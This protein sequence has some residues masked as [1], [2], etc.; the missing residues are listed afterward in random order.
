VDV[1]GPIGVSPPQSTLPGALTNATLNRYGPD[2]KAAAVLAATNRLLAD[3]TAAV[4]AV[5]R[6][7]A[8]VDCDA[9]VQL[10]IWAGL[11]VE[12]YRAQPAL[13]VAAIQARQVQRSL[14]AR[15]GT[16]V[17]RGRVTGVD[18]PSE[19]HP[20]DGA[21]S[22]DSAPDAAVTRWQPTSFDLVDST[23]PLL[24]LADDPDTGRPGLVPLD[25]LD[26][27]ASAWCQRLLGIG[28]PGRGV[29]W[30]AE[31]PNGSRRTYAMVRVG[32]VVAPFV[33]AT[34]GNIP[35]DDRKL[36]LPPLPDITTLKA[37][38]LLHR[39]AYLLM[40]HVVSNYV[41]YHGL[42]S[43]SQLRTQTREL[44][45]TAVQL[46][47]EV[48]DADDPVTLQLQAYA[49]YLDVWALPRSRH[50]ASSAT[51]GPTATEREAA[52]Q[53]LIAAQQ[54]V[55]KAWR[56]GQLDPGAAAYLL[57]IGIVA[58]RDA[59]DP[60]FLGASVVKGPSAAMIRSWWAAILE[61][62]GL[63][64]EAD[65]AAL[66][67][68]L[69]EAQVFHLH[70][71]VDW[72]AS[73]GRRVDLRRVVIGGDDVTLAC[74]AALAVPFVRA[75]ADAFARHTA[76]QPALAAIAEAATGH[77]ALTASAGIA[78]VKPHHPFSTAYNLAEALTVS[79][80]RFKDAT[81]RT[82]AAFDIH[83]A[84]TSTLRDLDQLREYIHR[85]HAPSIAR[86]A[87]PYLL[88]R[89]EELPDNL[90][91]RSVEVLDEISGW[92]SPGGWLSAAQAHALREAADRSWDEYRIQV[93]L[94]IS[95][96]L[97]RS[98]PGACWVFRRIAP[99]VPGLPLP[100]SFACLTRC[101]CA[102]SAWNRQLSQLR[103]L[104]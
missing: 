82:L 63:D 31:G 88:G 64:P 9:E 37:A 1:V 34:L 53:R 6:H 92:L 60:K 69:N 93:D 25:A 71:Y 49:A 16:Q 76:A 87:G 23:L 96:L 85:D 45:N 41:R 101:T 48:L 78:V 72:L 2:T 99:R 58:L 86:Y 4:A 68:S 24:K 22:R 47:A 65:L 89:T 102:A 18:A 30:L 66:I 67:D 100:R 75:F 54:H 56:N 70:N 51:S 61:A 55:E 33:A 74:D 79:A 43:Q 36:K 98:G 77:R 91:D 59:T 39:R 13:V 57:E 46:C 7:L 81:G 52:I 40:A 20:P 26:D 12:V 42:P 19:I 95:A 80:K 11:I 10:A 27:I 44:V 17:D 97:I 90:R 103:T 8:A 62:R 29:V 84:H 32:A 5:C 94:V 50:Q 3:A 104:K 15:W 28:Q 73:S 38:P 35:V 21:S 14:S 83:I